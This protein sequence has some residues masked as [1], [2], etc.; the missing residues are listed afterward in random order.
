M[1]NIS[2]GNFYKYFFLENPIPMWIFQESD[3]KIIA[4]NDTACQYYG[5]TREEFLK[6]SIFD[7]RPQEDIPLLQEHLKRHR[8]EKES[9]EKWRHIKKDGTIIYVDIFSHSLLINNKKCRLIIAKDITEQFLAQKKFNQSE[10]IFKTLMEKSSFGIFIVQNDKIIFANNEFEKIFG[11]KLDEIINIKKINDFL[12]NPHIE[13]NQ[14]TIIQ[15]LKKEKKLQKYRTKGLRKDGKIIELEVS[16]ELVR[17]G[18]QETIIGSVND[19]TELIKNAE[20]LQYHLELEKLISRISTRFVDIEI[21][22]IDIAIERA[23]KE[24]GEFLDVDRSYVFQF[25]DDGK[26]MNNTH[27]WCARGIEPQIE[28]LQNLQTEDFKWTMLLLERYSVI[29][30]PDVANLP[31]EARNEKEILQAQDIQSLIIVPMIYNKKLLGF[32]GFDSVIRKRDWAEEFVATLKMLSEIISTA[33]QRII[34]ESKLKKLSNALWQTQDIV[35][36]TDKDGIIEF[37]NPSFERI[38]GYSQNEVIGKKPNILKSEKHDSQFYKKLWNTIKNGKSFDTEFINKK[39][40][41]TIY[42]QESIITPMKDSNDNITHFIC[43]GRDIT[44]R[45]KYE[46]MRSRLTSIL[47]ATSDFV[48]TADKNYN[49]LYINRAGKKMVG[50]DEFANC[51]NL[52]ISDFHPKWAAEKIYNEA[53]PS[54]VK[55][56]IWMGETALL[57]SDN[58]EIPT[59]QVIITH[60]DQTGNVEYF[61]TVIRDITNL[62]KAQEEIL[63]INEILKQKVQ[64]LELSKKEI[65]KLL[66]EVTEKNIA[67]E[68]ISRDLVYTEE[69]ERRRFSRELHDSLGQTLTSL[70]INLELANKAINSQENCLQKYLTESQNL[71]EEAFKEVKQL[72]Y[73]MRPAVLDDFGLSAAL[74][75]LANQ[76]YNRFNILVYLLI[77]DEDERY[78]PII[79]TALYRIAQE[80]LTNVAKHSNAKNVYIQLINRGNVLAFTITDDGVGFDVQKNLFT[81]DDALHFGLKNIRERV[82]FLGGKLYIESNIGHGT[83]ISIEINLNVK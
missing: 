70:K 23:L 11:Y 44:E 21:E 14:R 72:S 22:N 32:I 55:N 71:I 76:F 8:P 31:D 60:K 4:V 48:S 3:Y 19:I 63:A 1:I 83:E 80:C 67:L 46:E 81:E 51:S 66:T 43:I 52:C 15:T 39:K 27:E 57:T 82:E 62:K 68:K 17:I 36:I 2:I 58:L 78:E 35:I 59:S 30:I 77:G 20:A 12:H 13:L 38:T 79:E 45:K 69:R 7:I 73:D 54:A 34:S 25:T 56:G 33:I 40:D 18:E 9:G 50:L 75:L 28:N 41:G 5:Y 64:D 6:M 42:Y 24:I 53:L 47:E 49:I 10:Q 61:S 29:T 65:S 26:Y 37:I 16:A 74:R